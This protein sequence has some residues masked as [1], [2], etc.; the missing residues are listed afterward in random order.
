MARNNVIPDSCAWIDFL[1]GKESPLADA[2]AESLENGSAATCGVVMYELLQGIRSRREEEITLT[3]F[4]ALPHL[5]MTRTLW[6]K[7][8]KLSAT[9]RKQGVI[10]PLSDI[11]IATLA[12]EH[13]MAVLT[14]DRHFDLIPE[15]T[16]IKSPQGIK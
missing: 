8:G 3:A 11:V 2:L 14:I 1:N 4:E 13:R 16:V 5:E 12:I 10:L 6:I 15:L 7:A 9:L